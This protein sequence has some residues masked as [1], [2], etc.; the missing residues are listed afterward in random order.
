MRIRACV[1]YLDTIFSPGAVDG[2]LVDVYGG[3]KRLRMDNLFLLTK[4]E[5]VFGGE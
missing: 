2:E 1:S 5:D 3:L 4:I